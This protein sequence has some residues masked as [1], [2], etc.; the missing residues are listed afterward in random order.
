MSRIKEIAKE[1]GAALTIAALTVATTGARVM[2]VPADD[3]GSGGGGGGGVATGN[4]QSGVSKVNPGAATDLYPMIQ[5]ILN[6]VFTIIGVVA[7]IMIVIGGVNYTTS[8][9]DSAKVQKAKNTIMYGIIGLVIVLL[10][11]AIVNFV[12]S[13]LLGG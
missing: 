2:A 12:L 8:Q 6:M 4:A 10:S 13:G 9:G 5:L 11:F 7:V 3:E 1:A